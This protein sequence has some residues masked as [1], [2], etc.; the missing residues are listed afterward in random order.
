MQKRSIKHV[1]YYSFKLKLIN[2]A[3][4]VGVIINTKKH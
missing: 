1:F 3:G 4:V 2:P